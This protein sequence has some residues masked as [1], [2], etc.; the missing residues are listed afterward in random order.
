M[1]T[2]IDKLMEHI[3]FLS[4]HFK[5]T[6][7]KYI[8]LILLMEL[9]IPT[10]YDGF[11]YLEKAICLYSED[12][13]RMILHGLYPSVAA[14]YEGKVSEKQIEQA[15]RSALKVAWEHRDPQIWSLYMQSDIDM[16]KPSNAEFITRI[17][18]LVEMWRGCCEE[19]TNSK[20]G[21]V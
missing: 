5:R 16:R 4:R 2:G 20:E 14:I 13:S 3:F 11:D 21:A 10:K 12:P 8:V 18:R 6:E 7:T 9:D 17:A 1:R 15:I 19:H